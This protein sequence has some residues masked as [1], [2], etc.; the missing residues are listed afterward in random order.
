MMKR[1]FVCVTL[2]LLL[3]SF[4]LALSGCGIDQ[5]GE[6]A[7]EGHRRHVRLMRLQRQQL[8]EDIDML[9]LLDKSTR[10]CEIYSVMPFGG[11]AGLTG[12]LNE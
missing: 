10:T 9:L 3:V 1:V 5:M 12:K 4:A 11:P 8:I 2:F 6:T 7:A